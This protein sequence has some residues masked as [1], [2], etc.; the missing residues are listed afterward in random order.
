MSL[1]KLP[2][3]NQIPIFYRALSCL[4]LV[5]AL[6]GI[7]YIYNIPFIGEYIWNIESFIENV[8]GIDPGGTIR[9]MGYYVGERFLTAFI[10]YGFVI[11]TLNWFVLDIFSRLMFVFGNKLERTFFVLRALLVYYFILFSVIASIVFFG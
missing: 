10:F 1:F 8:L 2:R 4:G 11:T 3:I 6:V 5:T 7:V 9:I